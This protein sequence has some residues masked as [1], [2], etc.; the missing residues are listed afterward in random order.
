MPPSAST[1]AYYE[2]HAKEYFERTVTA[3]LSD[4]YSEFL[5]RLPPGARVL[6]VGAGS[7]RDLRFFKDSGFQAVG[8]DASMQLA[9]MAEEYSGAPCSVLSMED[10]TA[11]HC[12]EGI[13][14]CASL[15]HIP[16][17]SVGKVLQ[18][19][20]TALV[21][22]GVL[23][24]SLKEGDGEAQAQDGRFYALYR[25]MEVR[26]LFQQSKFH[27]AKTWFTRD[28]LRE[29]V[30]APRWLNIIAEIDQVK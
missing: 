23:F 25:L 15:L 26:A 29:G 16:K 13:W 8:I 12:Y 19:L 21:H 4:L 5:F 24:V 9:R 7:G 20:H 11:Q 14:A 6:D 28:V 27:I 1:R 17:G 22:G 3:D 2:T 10:I 30:S 18:K